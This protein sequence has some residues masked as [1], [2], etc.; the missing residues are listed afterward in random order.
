MFKFNKFYWYRQ[1][2]VCDN[3]NFN[4]WTIDRKKNKLN[5]YC[6]NRLLWFNCFNKTFIF[7]YIKYVC[8]K[9]VTSIIF[10]IID[11]NFYLFKT[12]KNNRS[13]KVKLILLNK[14]KIERTFK[15]AHIHIFYQIKTRE[16]Y[17]KFEK[18]SLQRWNFEV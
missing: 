17:L 14:H 16:Y 8:L 6:I 11:N 4:R 7:R 18:S 3:F 5:Y 13:I 1:C 9:I 12:C 2:F 15:A 10:F